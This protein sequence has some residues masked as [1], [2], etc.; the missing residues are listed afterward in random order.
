MTS[1]ANL[2]KIKNAFKA[3][4]TDK[5]TAEVTFS[6]PLWE[7]SHN[8]HNNRLRI[9]LFLN[10]LGIYCDQEIENQFFSLVA[11]EG[12]TFD[13]IYITAKNILGSREFSSASALR[14]AILN[15]NKR[16]RKAIISIALE[17]KKNSDRITNEVINEVNRP[18]S[19]L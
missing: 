6:E 10:S 3:I 13:E 12:Q 17:Q 2:L 11:K 19:F 9:E 8:G 1:I 16:M 5:V 14:A 7:F 4:L 18:L 15:A